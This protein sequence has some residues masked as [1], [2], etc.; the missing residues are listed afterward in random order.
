MLFRLAAEGR[1]N[2]PPDDGRRDTFC[3]S[4]GQVSKARVA[5][6]LPSASS[7]ISTV[8]FSTT[9]YSFE[10]LAPS[11]PARNT[12]SVRLRRVHVRRRLARRLKLW[13]RRFVTDV[14]LGL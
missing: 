12:P 14:V 5:G 4:S 7:L 9:T 2:V 13:F 11:A 10:S 3:C 1:T 6:R 8:R